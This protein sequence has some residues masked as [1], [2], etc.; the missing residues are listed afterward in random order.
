M[1][2]SRRRLRFRLSFLAMV[3]LL[4]TQLAFATH[5]DCVAAINAAIT[6]GSAATAAQ[7]C[8]HKLG[9]TSQSVCQG[10]C[11]QGEV[12]SDVGRVPTVPPLAY[13]TYDL[14]KR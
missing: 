11:D 4:W 1:I 13:R 7:G 2:A 5:S 8:E 14:G 12:S 10:H 9:S 3:A 6:A